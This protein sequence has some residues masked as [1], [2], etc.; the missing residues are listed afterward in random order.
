M[1]LASWLADQ[2][3]KPIVVNLVREGAE[4]D[5]ETRMA[6]H[7]NAARPV[8]F[9]RSAWENLLRMPALGAEAARPLRKYAEN[10]T[11]NFRRAF[12]LEHP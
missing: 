11:I 7:L 5:V 6:S 12:K 3:E 8:E 2:N 9:K 4:T 10:K 1:V